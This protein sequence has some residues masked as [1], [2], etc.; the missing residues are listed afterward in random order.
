MNP[1]LDFSGLPRFS[2]F[3]T[4]H[5]TPAIDSL[6][7]ENRALVEKL[8]S[9]DVPPTWND[10]VEPLEDGNERLAR[11]HDFPQSKCHARLSIRAQCCL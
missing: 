9:P 1:L 2:D 5:V 11:F 6:L 4:G 7:D 10:F 3:A 8:A